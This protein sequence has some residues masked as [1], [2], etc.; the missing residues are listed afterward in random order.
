MT[1]NRLHPLHKGE[2]ELQAQRGTPT[3]LTR[4]LPSYIEADMPLQHSEFYS[5]LPYLPLA[6]LDGKGRPWV[7]LL[8]TQV[9]DKPNVGIRVAGKNKLSLT[10]EVSTYDPF[11]RALKEVSNEVNDQKRLFAG[12]GI[13]FSNRRRNKLAGSIDKFHSAPTG[14]INLTLSS[15]QH[16]GNCPKYITV[17]TLEHCER[18]ASLVI[19]C[20]DSFNTALPKAAKALIENASTAFLATKH[21]SADDEQSDMGLN[22]RGGMPGFVRVYEQHD[23]EGVNTYLVLPDHSGNRFYQSLG[24]IETDK[25]VGLVFPDFTNGNILYVTGEAENLFE[26][27]AEKLMP[28]VTLLTQIRITGA[29]YVEGGVNLAMTATEQLSPYNPPLRYLQQ[30]LEQMG[31]ADLSSIAD[32]QGISASLVALEQL[33]SSVSTFTFA[34]SRSI[35][36]P[37]PGGFAVFDFSQLIQSQYRHMDEMNPQSVNDDY[38]RTW[39]LSSSADFNSENNSFCA[40]QQI[41]ITVKRKP[42]GLISNFLHDNGCHNE[43]LC[44]EPMK[45]NFKGTGVGFSCFNKVQ[46]GELPEV[47]DKM[48]WLAGG[49]GITPFMAMWD[50]ITNVLNALPSTNEQICTDIILLFSGRDDDIDLLQHF[51]KHAESLPNQLKVKAIAFQSVVDQA[52]AQASYTSLMEQFAPTYLDVQQRRLTQADLS[53]VN[54]L[55]DREVFLCG[56]DGLMD[57]VVKSLQ[58]IAGN[59]LKLHRESYFF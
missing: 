47:P 53:N 6:T 27:D 17:R 36:V 28:R 54:D 5:E 44:N 14:Q 30:E 18:N 2:L 56:P 38:I 23:S 58:V 55:L 4:H 37:L 52:S 1:S 20:L 21:T 10:A 46:S 40:V 45:V 50:G 29:V 25:Q 22:H 43:Q 32:E 13:D 57:S 11:V 26:K 9:P 16:L 48:L 19:D 15:T 41:K 12:V 7:S 35:D 42:G 49:V 8:V 39:T 31:R 24:N 51:L 33:T 59:D 3:E 34:L